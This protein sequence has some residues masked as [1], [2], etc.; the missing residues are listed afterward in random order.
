MRE[1]YSVTK[2]FVLRSKLR[3]RKAK[4]SLQQTLS[5]NRVEVE[6]VKRVNNRTADSCTFAENAKI[7]TTISY[8]RSTLIIFVQVCINIHSLLVTRGKETI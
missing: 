3:C 1:D 6:S 8:L 4:P 2:R 5:R 7:R